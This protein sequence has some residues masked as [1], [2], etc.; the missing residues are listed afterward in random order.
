MS[1]VTRKKCSGFGGIPLDRVDEA[2]ENSPM[3][4]RRISIGL[5]LLFVVSGLAIASWLGNP[6]YPT[7]LSGRNV[8]G[9][10]PDPDSFWCGAAVVGANL[11]GPYLISWELV[12]VGLAVALW[13]PEWGCGPCDP[14]SGVC[15]SVACTLPGSS[16]WLATFVGT[17]V[18]LAF[19]TFLVERR[20]RVRGLLSNSN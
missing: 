17:G 12:L 10:L 1:Q 18:A 3:G 7:R 4:S 8:E 13:G 2:A 5:G 6:R 9:Q 14:F 11:S 20:R 15:V 19:A 16:F